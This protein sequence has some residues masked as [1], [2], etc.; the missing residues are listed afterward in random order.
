MNRSRPHR[1]RRLGQRPGQMRLVRRQNNCPPPRALLCRSPTHRPRPKLHQQLHHVLC[2]IHVEVR[3]WLVQQQQLRVRLQHPRQRSPL[4]HSLGVLPH[5]PRQRRVQS[6]RSQRLLRPAARATAVQPCEVAQVL[7]RRQL[8]VEHRLVAHIRNATP[9]PA[10]L[11][12]EDMHRTAR[13]RNQPR[14]QPQ[15][16]RFARPI[17]SQHHR[18]RARRKLHRHLAQRRESPVQLRHR[19]Q[20]RRR[21]AHR[22]IRQSRSICLGRFSHLSE[23]I[24]CS[25][26]S[27]SV[28]LKGTGSPVPQTLRRKRGF[29]P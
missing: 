2:R 1:Q 12:A 7:H 25:F 5:S 28:L 27:S 15:Q 16:R 13:R 9:L 10:R 26:P 17:L 3:E 29:S 8:V 14:N 21:H 19:I 20:P 24:E 11:V 22:S 23:Y 4:L 6:H 18:R